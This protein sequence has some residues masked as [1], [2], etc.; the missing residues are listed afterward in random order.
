MNILFTGNMGA[1]SNYFFRG[2]SRE[3]RLVV[4]T[5][6]PGC[7]YSGK[8][9]EV[10]KVDDLEE[11]PLD[12]VFETYHFKMVVYF[13]QALDE[14]VQV[15]DEL[16]K[17]ENA[18]FLC[19]EY[20]I[21]NFIYIST[22]D[23][24]QVNV[25]EKS[26][27]MILVEAC[28]NMCR[29]F[30]MKT[31]MNILLM[32]V[33]YLYGCAY[34]QNSLCRWICSLVDKVPMECRGRSGAVTDFLCDE[35]LAVLLN[36]IADEP[37]TDSYMEMNL[38]GGN[39]ITFQEL[40]NVLER[41]LEWCKVEYGNRIKAVPICFKDEIA[42]HQYGWFP[43]HD[44]QGDLSTIIRECRQ[45][46]QQ[47]KPKGLKR[48]VTRY[49][50]RVRI[51][52]ELLVLLA[53]AMACNA[54]CRNNMYINFIDFRVLYVVI[55]GTMNGLSAGL[56]AAFLA[57]IGYGA[58]NLRYSTWE[59]LFYNVQNWLPFVSYILI[60]AI[61]GYTKDKHTSELRFLKEEGQILERKYIFL[62]E[63]YSKAVEN[64]NRFNNQ[65]ISYKDS[66]GRIYAVVK[67]LNT[68]LTDEI[69]FEAVNALEDVLENRFVA[70]YSI[71][72]NSNF[73][74][75]NVCSKRLNAELGK[76]LKLSD[77]PLMYDCLQQGQ[78][79]TNKS[80]EEN[81]PSY[82]SPVMR[83]GELVG[84]IVLQYVEAKQMNMEFSNKFMIIAD[85][86]RD[87]LIRAMDYDSVTEQHTMLE[88]TKI[89]R[90]EKFESILR[91]KRQ[92]QEKEYTEYVLLRIHREERD[93]TELSELVSGMVR[94][95]DVLGMGEDGEVYLL[96]AQTSGSGLDIV[97]ERMHSKGI[98]FDEV[99]IS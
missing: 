95:N 22:N 41:K 49:R 35:D 78:L 26:S 89:M 96:L 37:I 83:E 55:M 97:N 93:L 76:S 67:K 15:F 82:A 9:L 13:S 64:K 24:V 38:P 80:C 65:I 23:M 73:A 99:S 12:K 68:T 3:H 84:M 44:L 74:R 40:S 70:I 27:R 34:V 31:D 77:Y 51:A 60:G 72:A 86:V 11:K 87:S 61:A 19:T 57:M 39:E 75:L 58:E 5:A 47:K 92:M 62:S 59:L 88:G 90:P 10:Y 30:S 36:R 17:L 71:A 14:A 48:L 20:R 66:F 69:F 4:H 32:R 63:L 52:I 6:Q 79:F 53:V 2:F 18:L 16:E 46:K 28:E 43:V 45:A 56:V 94:A 81:Y 50:N 98:H 8:N 54:L 7:K 29:N 85:L 25:K 42:R 33:P 1:I 21:E 91:I